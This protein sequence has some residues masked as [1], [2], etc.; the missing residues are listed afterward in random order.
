MF[1]ALGSQETETVVV[2]NVKC[3]GQEERKLFSKEVSSLHGLI[4]TNV[5][6]FKA[7]C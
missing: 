7:M 4:H 6:K 5:V 1:K 3:P 2:K